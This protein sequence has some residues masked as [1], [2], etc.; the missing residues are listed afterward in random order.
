MRIF[1]PSLEKTQILRENS[2]KRQWMQQNSTEEDG[3][4]HSHVK[5]HM[6]QVKEEGNDVSTQV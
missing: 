3:S 1:K 4:I 6:Q 5:G 2:E